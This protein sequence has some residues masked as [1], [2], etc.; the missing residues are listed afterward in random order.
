MGTALVLIGIA[1]AFPV[2][3]LNVLEYV[4]VRCEEMAPTQHLDMLI[5]LSDSKATSTG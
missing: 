3:I 4:K 2:R 5:L 1:T